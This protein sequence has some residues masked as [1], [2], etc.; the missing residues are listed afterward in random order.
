MT[1][2]QDAGSTLGDETDSKATVNRVWMKRRFG[3]CC[4]ADL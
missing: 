2:R 1:F 3:I 4:I